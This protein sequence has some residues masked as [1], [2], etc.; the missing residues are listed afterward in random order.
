M[1]RGD[2][3]FWLLLLLLSSPASTC[4]KAGPGIGSRVGLFLPLLKRPFPALAFPQL[5]WRHVGEFA[6][7]SEARTGC[8]K[9]TF[10]DF[11][12]KKEKEKRN[13]VGSISGLRNE[14][15]NGRSKAAGEGDGL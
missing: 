1:G 10:K 15:A 7:S 5:Q 12:L 3:P 13:S 11:N 6:G 14:Q 2:G 4:L 8:K 9:R